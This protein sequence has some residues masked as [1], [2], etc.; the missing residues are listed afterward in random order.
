MGKFQSLSLN[1]A[2]SGKINKRSSVSLQKDVPKIIDIFNNDYNFNI[3]N[4]KGENVGEKNKTVNTITSS[5][6]Q[7]NKIYF[8]NKTSFEYIWLT[9]KNEYLVNIK[10][11]EIYF[12]INDITIYRNVNVEL[13]FFFL[14]NNF[15]NWDF[16]LGFLCNRIFIFF[17]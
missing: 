9:P 13:I 14:E 10:T 12:Y 16:K 3:I 4:K 6:R 8:S 15:I 17:L 11:P 2:L 1:K 7:S 5:N